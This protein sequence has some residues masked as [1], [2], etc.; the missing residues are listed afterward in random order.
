MKI[1][2]KGKK[3]KIIDAVDYV[4]DLFHEESFWEA[5]SEKS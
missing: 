5:I 2:Y 1:V 4:N 3:Q